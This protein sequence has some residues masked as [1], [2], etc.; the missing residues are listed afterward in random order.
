MDIST[1]R[2]RRAAAQRRYRVSAK[3]RITNARYAH[4]LRGKSRYI[5]YRA[6]ERGHLLRRLNDTRPDV[7]L[8]KRLYMQAYEEAHC[9]L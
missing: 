8:K 1:A 9:L 4:S 2:A 7:L 6:T 5:R 3:G